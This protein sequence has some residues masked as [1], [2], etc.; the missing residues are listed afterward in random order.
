MSGGQ[1]FAD[2]MAGMGIGNLPHMDLDMNE[3]LNDVDRFMENID[4]DIEMTED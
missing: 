3:Q 2:R 1:D 4:K